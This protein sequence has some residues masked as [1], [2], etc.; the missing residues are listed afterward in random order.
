MN[1]TINDELLQSLRVILNRVRT[2]P[3]P[4]RPLA[5]EVREVNIL[6]K[7]YGGPAVQAHVDVLLEENHD[8]T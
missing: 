2:K 6:V 1:T 4:A 7:Q 8:N 5:L 3:R